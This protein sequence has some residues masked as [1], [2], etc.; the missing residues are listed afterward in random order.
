MHSSPVELFISCNI[1]WSGRFA[2]CVNPET[3]S[4]LQMSNIVDIFSFE[5]D[6]VNI[7]IFMWNAS[8]RI[9]RKG[10]K[11]AESQLSCDLVA[12]HDHS[13]PHGLTPISFRGKL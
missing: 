12:R 3:S 5:G 2:C 6:G 13:L 4:M 7:L 11:Q 10:N 1:F 9:S 8:P